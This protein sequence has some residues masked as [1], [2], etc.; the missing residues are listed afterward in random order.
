MFAT[1][2][3][4]LSSPRAGK[5]RQPEFDGSYLFFF[6]SGHVLTYTTLTALELA[7]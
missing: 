6:A 4:Q 2:T 1:M 7:M 3:W 5:P